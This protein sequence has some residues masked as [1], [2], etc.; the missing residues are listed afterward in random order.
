MLLPLPWRRP[1]HASVSVGIVGNAAEAQKRQKVPEEAA[2]GSPD[3]EG[4]G[5]KLRTFSTVRERGRGE[6]T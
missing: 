5:Q 4:L 6:E 3:Q 2:R 1:E